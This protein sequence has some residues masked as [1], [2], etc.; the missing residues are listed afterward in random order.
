MLGEAEACGLPL[1]PHW[2]SRFLTDAAAPSV[3][4][5]RGWSRIFVLRHKRRIGLDRPE[6]IHPTA[7]SAA[8]QAGLPVMSDG[9]LRAS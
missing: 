9:A 8:R 5:L 3:G 1:P 7:L 6:K 2:R 4:T